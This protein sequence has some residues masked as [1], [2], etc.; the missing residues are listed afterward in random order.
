MSDR[1]TVII[2]NSAKA[3][4]QYYHSPEI[5]AGIHSC[6]EYMYYYVHI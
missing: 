3:N 4:V 5:Y 1:E 6:T 2:I